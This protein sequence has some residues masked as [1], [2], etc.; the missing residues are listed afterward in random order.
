M[1]AT[2]GVKKLGG[3]DFDEIMLKLVGKKF[4]KKTGEEMD[5]Q[6]YTKNM[7]ED[8]KIALSTQESCM[9]RVS[10]VNLEITRNE[11]EK[12]I[13]SL[14]AQTEMLCET[15]IDEA[16]LSVDDI[17]GVFLVGGS[18]R[19]PCVRESVLK[20]FKKE[21]ISSANV[22]EVVALGA[23]LY[24]AYKSDRSQL[25]AVQKKAVGQ[26]KVSEISGKCFGLI[27]TREDE[28]RK[29]RVTENSVIITKGEKIPISIT[30][31][32]AT[33]DDGQTGLHCQVTESTAPETDP[34]FVKIIWTGN[35][36]L[37]PGRPKDQ[38]IDVTFSYNDN[39]I[40]KCSFLDVASDKKEDVDLEM[41]STSKAEG[42]DIEKF[43][44]E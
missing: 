35:L 14:I 24:A 16:K 6:D 7:A 17:K 23:A 41:G 28:A 10:R 19:I 1:L 3:D 15:T 29:K 20:V 38:V 33:V 26:I 37:P 2:G 39:Q 18:T 30:K 40:M 42:E 13:S 11:F 31:Q 43:I 12:A 25:N 34:K 8:E 4:K 27:S 36:E 32:Y 22:D 21:P 5:P 9:V 44:V